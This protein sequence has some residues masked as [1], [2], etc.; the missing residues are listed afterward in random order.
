M[1][2]RVP[3]RIAR[4]SQTT[5]D[6]VPSWVWGPTNCSGRSQM[7][8]VSSGGGGVDMVDGRRVP[9]I[10]YSSANEP[11][12]VGPPGED[13]VVHRIGVD[14]NER[15]GG[16]GQQA[17]AAPHA[18]CKARTCENQIPPLDRVPAGR[19]RPTWSPE[20]QAAPNAAVATRRDLMP[21][22]PV[23]TA[24]ERPLNSYGGSFVKCG[25]PDARGLGGH[26]GRLR[27]RR[28]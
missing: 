5:A 19:P 24:H 25:A 12:P 11:E 17:V 9:P 23:D 15:L 7:R 28:A 18:V 14:H 6:L 4:G 22:P 8:C 10:A 2:Q 1:P 3:R 26:P 16:R 20:L 21:A 13:L 27:G